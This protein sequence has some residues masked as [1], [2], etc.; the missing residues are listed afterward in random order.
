MERTIVGRSRSGRP[1]KA[2]YHRAAS[3]AGGGGG[4][5]QEEGL[6][7]G[8]GNG[9]AESFSDRGSVSKAVDGLGGFAFLMVRSVRGMKNCR[10]IATL[11]SE[12]QLF[13][14]LSHVANSSTI[15]A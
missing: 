8:G 1:A 14:M 9:D 10:E 12:I 13:P 4:V 6:A 2:H 5:T 11:G 3:F 7:A 15:S